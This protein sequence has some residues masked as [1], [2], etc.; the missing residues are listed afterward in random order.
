M[1]R[2]FA[3]VSAV[4]RAIEPRWQA[5]AASVRARIPAAQ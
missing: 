3:Q 1:L 5:F 4:L 2:G